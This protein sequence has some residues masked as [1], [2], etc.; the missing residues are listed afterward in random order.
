MTFPMPY[1]D[2]VRCCDCLEGLKE[3][4]DGC[5]DLVVTDPPYAYASTHGGGVLAL[6][7]RGTTPNWSPYPTV[8]PWRSTRSC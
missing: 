5:V 7:T 2:T 6:T 1:M 4:P 8:S 3:L